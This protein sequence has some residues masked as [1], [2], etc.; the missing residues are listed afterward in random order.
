MSLSEINFILRSVEKIHE[1]FSDF[2]FK[3]RYMR[4]EHRVLGSQHLNLANFCGP[5]S[6]LHILSEHFENMEMARGRLE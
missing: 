2:K 1:I 4:D 3:W 6:D 5:F